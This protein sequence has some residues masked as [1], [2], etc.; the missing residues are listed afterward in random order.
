MLSTRVSTMRINLRN[1]IRE[2]VAKMRSGVT[3]QMAVATAG[4]SL[5][6]LGA[7]SSFAQQGESMPIRIHAGSSSMNVD[8]RAGGLAIPTTAGNVAPAMELSFM[9]QGLTQAQSAEAAR[10]NLSAGSSATNSWANSGSGRRSEVI[11]TQHLSSPTAGSAVVSGAGESLNS[12]GHGETFVSSQP[13]IV[14]PEPIYSTDP[15]VI[16]DPMID[17]AYYPSMGNPGGVYPMSPAAFQG[18]AFT[19]C[20]PQDCRVYYADAEV[21]YWKQEEDQSLS[22]STARQLSDFDFEFGGRVTVGEMFDCVN[23]V[24]FVYT[25]PFEWNRT[26]FDNSGGLNSTF[27][28]LSPFALTDLDTFF[29]SNV[30]SQALETNL[31][32]YEINRR[33]FSSDLFST[34]LGLRFVDYDEKFGF[35]SVASDGVGLGQYF[36]NVDNFLVGAQFGATMYRPVSQRLAVGGWG[37]VG[38]FANFSKNRT[39]LLNRGNTLADA[40]RTDTSVAGLFQGGVGIRYR[41]LERLELTGG[42]EGMFLPGV[43]TV[44]AQQNFPLSLTSPNN[45]Q[46]DDNVFFHGLNAGIEL[47]Y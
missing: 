41:I 33:W 17:N 39:L 34:L 22:F 7:T 25:G 15:I 10:I 27:S 47:S 11:A 30:H 36:N 3:G 46:S 40:Q 18:G 9:T 6:S 45:V 19:A 31:S 42:Y 37:K 16:G 14:G 38:V 2:L 20:T 32:T 44:A 28:T 35:N 5:L 43:A 12:A 1:T 4:V 13:F 21:L 23:G 29:N 8:P 24:E 26:R